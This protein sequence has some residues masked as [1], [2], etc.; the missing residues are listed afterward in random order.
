MAAYRK[1]LKD[2]ASAAAAYNMTL[3]GLGG[4]CFLYLAFLGKYD[5][6]Q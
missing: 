3:A 2:A 1:D 5:G 6:N 4:M